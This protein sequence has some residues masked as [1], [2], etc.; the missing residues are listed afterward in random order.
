[1]DDEEFKEFLGVVILIGA[2]KS[3]NESIEQLWST[4]DGRPIFNCTMSRGRHQPFLRFLRFDNA[5]SRRHHWSPDKL[6]P[7][8]EVF[9]TWNSYLRDSY[10]CRPSMTVHEQLVCFR[11]R[12][13]FKQYIPLKPGK[14]RIKLCIICD[15]T[16]SYAWKMQVYIRKDAGSARETNQDTR[17]VY[18]LAEDIGNSGRNI[19]CDNFLTN[20]SLA[21]KLLQKKLT[22]IETIKKNKRK[23]PTEFAV[24]KGPNVKSTVFGFQLDAFIASYCS[25]TNRVVNMLSTMHS[26]P[27]IKSTSDQKPSIILFYNRTKGG[28][29][30]LDRM[31]RSYSTKRMARR[32]P[33]VLFYN[34]IDVST[35]NV[36]II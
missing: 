31:V 6:Q 27:E 13:L 16:C 10:I 30:P 33:L 4:L 3:N 5:Q 36:F 17:V 12:C 11:K 35:I 19:N 18:D 32:R 14:Y 1:M 20:L 24:A 29:D 23:L 28:V 25:K 15:S 21:Q 26:Q 22:V 7:I 2:Y 34:M 9:A 8:R